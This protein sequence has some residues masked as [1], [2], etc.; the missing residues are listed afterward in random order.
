LVTQ[1]QSTAEILAELVAQATA[2]LSARDR[3]E[4]AS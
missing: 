1:E 2:L 3:R 4:A